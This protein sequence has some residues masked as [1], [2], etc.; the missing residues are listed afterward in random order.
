MGG[1][2]K[3]AAEIDRIDEI[4][5]AMDR[6]CQGTVRGYWNY[7][8]GC[9]MVLE[10]IARASGLPMT[11]RLSDDMLADEVKLCEEV[12]AGHFCIISGEA[13]DI[14]GNYTAAQRLKNI[15]VHIIYIGPAVD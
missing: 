7:S 13:S 2:A 15:G 4:A 10:N 9:E 11:N 6:L 12:K 3:I 1:G 5:Q 8:S 14:E